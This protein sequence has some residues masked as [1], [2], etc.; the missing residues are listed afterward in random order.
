MLFLYKYFHWI[1]NQIQENTKPQ[2]VQTSSDDT[3]TVIS[4]LSKKIQTIELKGPKNISVSDYRDIVL[5]QIGI[6]VA[7]AFSKDEVLLLPNVY[8]DFASKFQDPSNSYPTLIIT[9]K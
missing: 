8:R 6:E 4:T 1:L 3:D 9:E 2:Q 7:L 5:C